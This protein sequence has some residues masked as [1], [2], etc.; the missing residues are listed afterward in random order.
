MPL[1]R[2]AS[3]ACALL[4]GAACAGRTDDAPRDEAC[5]AAA[6]L[7]RFPVS[8]DEGELPGLWPGRAEAPSAEALTLTTERARRGGR[9]R[10]GGPRGQR[11]PSC[12]R[13]T[14]PTS[15]R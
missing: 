3:L 14:T 5:G 4:L 10:A 9:A 15:R 11:R 1:A 2:T 12:C 6:S 13:R 8:F 7:A